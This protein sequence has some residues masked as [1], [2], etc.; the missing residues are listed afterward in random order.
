[1][2]A[3]AEA[4]RLSPSGISVNSPYRSVMWCGCHGVV[5][6]RVSATTG[7]ASSA[8]TSTTK[9]GSCAASGSTSMPIQNTWT[10]AIPAA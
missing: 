5:A 8:I 9:T 4:S 1:M 2:I 10:T 3:L 7:T 6:P